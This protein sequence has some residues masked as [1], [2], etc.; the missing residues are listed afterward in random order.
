MSRFKEVVG[1]V[2]IYSSAFVL[3]QFVSVAGALIIRYFL[4][5]LQ[6][7][8]WSL[9]QVILSYI[10]YVN[11]GATYAIPI[12]IPFKRA[13]GK[14]EETE[15]MKNV[16][17]SFS[18]LTSMLFSIGLFVY[19]CIRRSQIPRELFYG[20]LIATGLVILQ[21]LN[22]VLISFLRAYKNFK[23]AGKQMAL[24]SV[25]NFI[26]VAILSSTFRLYGFMWAMVLSFVFNIVY[27]LYHENFRFRWTLN[28]KVLMG[29]IQYGFPLMMLTLAGTVLLTIDKMMIAKYLGLEALGLYSIAMMTAGF[30]CSVPNSIGVVLLPNVSEKYAEGENVRDLRGYL[31]KSNHVFSILMPI[32]IGLGWFVVPFVVNLILPKFEGGIV[33]LK[34]LALSTFFVGL[35]QTYSNA[36]VVSKKHFLQFPIAMGMCFI[37]F[38]LLFL[39]IKT[40]AGINE[41]AIIMTAVMMV[42]FTALHLLMGRYIFTLGELCREYFLVF[43]NFVFMILVLIALDRMLGVLPLLPR[44]FGQIFSLVAVYLPFLIHINRKYEV[45]PILKEKFLKS[46]RFQKV[47]S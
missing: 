21:Q 13:Q 33:A 32:L 11:L 37:A 40:G 5:P 34:Y 22:N 24:S 17:F 36:I 28:T 27:I 23:L 2:G 4:G 25:V 38:V 43:A 46:K 26:L 39:A 41:I 20:L 7:G 29:L 47:A 8:V 10:D 35:T 31:K 18:F 44:M 16:M 14:I 42:N 15:K 6:T 45:W 9:V 30:I 3:T 19:A 12:E 1:Q